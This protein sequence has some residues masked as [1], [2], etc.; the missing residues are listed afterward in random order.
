MA[1]DSSTPGPATDRNNAPVIDPTRNVLD[2]VTAAIKRQDD[3][4]DVLVSTFTDRLDV[5]VKHVDDVLTMRS[6]H[7]QEMTSALNE[8]VDEKFKSVDMQLALIERQRVEQKADTQKAVDAALA[9]QKEAVREQTTASDLA[10]G[11]S[12][13]AMTKQVDQQGVTFA[14][15]IQG[16]ERVLQDLKDRVTRIESVKQGSTDGRSALIAIVSVFVSVLSLIAVVVFA[17][18]R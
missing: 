9:A 8:R 7:A 15:A 17:L 11:K 1:D 12:E 5:V 4:R 10:I 14:T 18:L 13:N 2:L 16:T 6:T 3:I